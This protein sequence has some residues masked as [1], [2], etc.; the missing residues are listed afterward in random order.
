MPVNCFKWVRNTSQFNKEFIQN[1]NED[2]DEGYFIE[3]D[4]QY[5]KKLHAAHTDLWFL[6]KR[7]ETK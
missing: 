6:S 2:S 5:P 7:K 3:I 4:I 1:Y